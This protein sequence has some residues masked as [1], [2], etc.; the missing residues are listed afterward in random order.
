MRA[1]AQWKHD[2]LLGARAVS[3]QCALA[4][5]RPLPL[6]L[7][8]LL[9]CL[10][11]HW[12]PR[13]T[14]SSTWSCC[15]S[16]LRPPT[17]GPIAAP[18]PATPAPAEP[19]SRDCCCYRCSWRWRCRSRRWAPD[20]WA[21]RRAASWASSPSPAVLAWLRPPA[22]RWAPRRSPALRNLDNTR[23]PRR[24]RSHRLHERS[25]PW[26]STAVSSGA[27]PPPPDRAGSSG[28]PEAAGRSSTSRASRLASPSAR[29]AAASTLVAPS[30]G[31]A[32]AL[33]KSETAMRR[34]APPAA[35]L[36]AVAASCLHV[37][38]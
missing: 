15:R 9:L 14:P 18:A 17:W 22:R 29:L 25:Y 13:G 32:S 37:A 11:A 5:R 34:P 6:V 27:R 35:A 30:G 24:K 33:E 20:L 19:G 10:P 2:H 7:R 26:R 16:R 38:G 3:W 8:G 31:G 28:G 12:S 1:A 21:R 4:L 36:L 23:G